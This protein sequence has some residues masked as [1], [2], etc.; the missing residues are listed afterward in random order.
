VKKQEWLRDAVLSI[1]GSMLVW[2]CSQMRED[3]KS[4]VVSVNNLSI[5]MEVLANQV[6]NESLSVHDHEDRLR[7]IEHDRH[8]R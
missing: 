1:V 5:K 7:V 6:A 4:L 8:A 2:L 3:F